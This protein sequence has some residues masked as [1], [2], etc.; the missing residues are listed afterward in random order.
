MSQA[1]TLILLPQT[2]YDGGS[3]NKIYNV[4][5]DAVQAAAYYLGNRDLQTVNINLHHVT[6]NIIIQA[7]LSGT[8]VNN[9]D[10]FNT[11]KL[12]ANYMAANN[13]PKADAANANMSINIEGNFVWLRARIQDFAHGVVNFIK[14]SY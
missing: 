3:N 8:P 10:W 7:S 5:G 4:N 2:A 12:E 13:S 11:F 14:V 9:S 1:S 6:G